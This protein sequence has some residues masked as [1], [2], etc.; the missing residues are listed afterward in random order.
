M[1]NRR[2]RYAARIQVSLSFILQAKVSA[3]NE[4]LHNHRFVKLTICENL[5]EIRASKE[6]NSLVLV[7]EKKSLYQIP[8]DEFLAVYK[9]QQNRQKKNTY[10]VE[11]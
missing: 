1:Y 7:D 11:R 2:N 9:K 10:E 5:T 3:E 4:H 6:G 8:R